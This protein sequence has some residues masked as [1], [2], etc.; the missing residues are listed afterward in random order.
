MGDCRTGQDQRIFDP[1][2]L[3]ELLLE[4]S[5]MLPTIPSFMGGLPNAV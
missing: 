1:M 2:P 3:Y 4:F 5:L